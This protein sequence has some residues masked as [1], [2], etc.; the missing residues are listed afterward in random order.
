[1]PWSI[2]IVTWEVDGNSKDRKNKELAFVGSLFFDVQVFV[3][4]NITHGDL[5]SVIDFYEIIRCT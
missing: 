5:K 1:M 4:F 3:E 2:S